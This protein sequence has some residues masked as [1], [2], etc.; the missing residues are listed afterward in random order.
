MLTVLSLKSNNFNSMQLKNACVKLELKVGPFF[1]YEF[2]R[3]Y[4]RYMRFNLPELF[5]PCS[6]QLPAL[7]LNQNCLS[8]CL[9]VAPDGIKSLM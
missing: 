5:G 3:L 2:T 6:S 4:V 7:T 8:V 1:R 9:A